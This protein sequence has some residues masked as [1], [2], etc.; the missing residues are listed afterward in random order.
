MLITEKESIIR[1]A[2]YSD[3]VVAT[4]YKQQAIQARIAK[5]IL[6]RKPINLTSDTEKLWRHICA[7]CW[8]LE[9]RKRIS[10]QRASEILSVFSNIEDVPVRNE[11]RS[12]SF[13]VFLFGFVS[14]CALTFMFKVPGIT[15]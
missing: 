13:V 8:D 4:H 11:A 12:L 14:A 9:P 3:D 7:P 10:A 6:P 1:K 5:G 15:H 2:P